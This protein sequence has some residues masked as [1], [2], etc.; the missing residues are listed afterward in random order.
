[1][2]D[3]H[4]NGDLVKLSGL[5]ERRSRKGHTYLSG[6]LGLAG[7]LVFRNRN[8]QRDG[9]PDFILFACPGKGAKNFDPEPAPER[10]LDDDTPDF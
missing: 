5:W 4:D 3:A 10:S 9:D 7:L 8:K 6:H 2:K 1:M